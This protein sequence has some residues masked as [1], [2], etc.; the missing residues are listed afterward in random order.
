M[1]EDITCD[2]VQ[3]HSGVVM[4]HRF[5]LV[6]RLEDRSQSWR[7]DVGH[8]QGQRGLVETHRT[9]HVRKRYKMRAGRGEETQT[10]SVDR[11][12]VKSKLPWFVFYF[13]LQSGF[14]SCIYLD[15]KSQA[16]SKSCWLKDFGLTLNSFFR[17]DS[18]DARKLIRNNLF[19]L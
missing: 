16:R 15:N 2:G 11:L 7:R 8:L 4:R 18:L 6:R 13:I 12:H 9:A 19:F 3:L 17:W 5:R 1:R 14:I 10:L